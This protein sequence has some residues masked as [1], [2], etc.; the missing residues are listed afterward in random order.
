MAGGQQVKVFQEQ[1]LSRKNI[2]TIGVQTDKFYVS[3]GSN[4]VEQMIGAHKHLMIRT[5]LTNQSGQT[6]WYQSPSNYWGVQW[7][8]ETMWT[9]SDWGNE[10]ID[11]T[12][13]KGTVI[14]D[15]VDST[16][17]YL[18]INTGLVKNLKNTKLRIGVGINISNTKGV[19][20]NTKITTDRI[21]NFYWDNVLDQYHIVVMNNKVTTKEKIKSLDKIKTIPTMNI[22][23][24][25]YEYFSMGYNTSE[26]I[27]VGMIYNF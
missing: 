3:V 26:G 7:P 12:N 4:I 22:S 24:I 23:W 6:Y 18:S 9:S 20:T 5:Q 25:F 27:K 1:S 17:T 11:Q 2:Q 16:Q 13:Y 19:H 8:K 10:L 14:S 15:W 21:V